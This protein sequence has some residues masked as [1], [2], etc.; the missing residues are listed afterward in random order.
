MPAYG[1]APSLA[2]SP[3]DDG[4]VLTGLVEAAS[5]RLLVKISPDEQV[6][7]PL[8]Q[9]KTRGASPLSPMPEGLVNVLSKDEI[10]DLIAYLQSGG[11]PKFHAFKK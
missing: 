1:L 11:K 10:L 9:V 6:P 5:G 4:R 2:T 7:V 3:C 8:D